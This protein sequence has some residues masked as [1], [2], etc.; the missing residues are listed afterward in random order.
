MNGMKNGEWRMI[1][2]KECAICN[3]EIIPL[4]E[5][6]IFMEGDNY[7]DVCSFKCLKIIEK[8]TK[9]DL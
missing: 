5:F 3:K 8:K 7:W 4:H 2:K 9:N 6:L 1:D